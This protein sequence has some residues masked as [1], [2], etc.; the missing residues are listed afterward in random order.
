MTIKYGNVGRDDLQKALD[1]VRVDYTGLCN[2]QNSAPLQFQP[3][4]TFC[5]MS[6]MNWVERSDSDTQDGI[7]SLKLGVNIEI[8]R[9]QA[10]DWCSIADLGSTTA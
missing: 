1:S 8:N 10:F 4:S 2:S 3:K 7:I 9:G 5:M 6:S